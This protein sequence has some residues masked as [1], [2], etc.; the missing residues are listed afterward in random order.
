MWLTSCPDPVGSAGDRCRE[1]P[2]P[3][4]DLDGGPAPW[5][6]ARNGVERRNRVRGHVPPAG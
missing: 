3:L 1:K 2:A 5:T 6:A 4:R